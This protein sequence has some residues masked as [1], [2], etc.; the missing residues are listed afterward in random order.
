V[1]RPTNEFF[2]K[3]RRAS[4]D[5]MPFVPTFSWRTF[6]LAIGD[7][8]RANK[9][10]VA[11]FVF[12]VTTK[13]FPHAMLLCGLKIGLDSGQQAKSWYASDDMKA[14]NTYNEEIVS[15]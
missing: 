12:G 1:G 14:I 11:I 8:H 7:G 4:P 15:R 10:D 13:D 9:N 5:Q 3:D 6:V 2:L